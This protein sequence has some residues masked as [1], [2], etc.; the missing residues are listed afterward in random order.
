MGKTY[1]KNRLSVCS[2]FRDKSPAERATLIEQAGGCALCLDWT[3]DHQA[4]AC[5]AKGK[6]GKFEV[7]KLQVGGSLCGKR[8]NHLLHG[9]GN[10][11]CNSVKRVMSSNNGMSNVLGKDVPGAPSIKEIEAAD[12]IHALLQLQLIPVKSRAV[13]QAS[14]FYDPGSNVNLVRKEFAKEAG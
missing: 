5:Q 9:S 3:G 7:C 11:Y 1:F 14:T 6:F 4:K 10:S 13:N 2:S 8:H 12:S